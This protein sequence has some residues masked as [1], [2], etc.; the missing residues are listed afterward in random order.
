[1]AFVQGMR[2]SWVRL[3]IVVLTLV[4]VVFVSL[5]GWQWFEDARVEV[6]DRSLFAGYV[7]VTA[8]PT[9]EFENPVTTSGGNVVLSF[10]V[11][12]LEKSCVPSWGGA[13]TLAEANEQ[14]DLDRRIA[15]VRQLNGTPVVSFGGQANTELAAACASVDRIAGAYEQVVERYDL[16]VID[17]D[18]EGEALADTAAHQRRAEA[19]VQLQA[20]HD[21]EVWVTLPVA[22]HGLTE[23]GLILVRTMLDAGVDLAGVNVM[24]M[25]YGAGK[26]PEASMAEASIEALK[27]THEQLSTL[28]ESAG[29]RQTDA[30][31]WRLIGATPMLGQNDVREE[32]FDLDDASEF[33]AFADEIELGRMSV[34]SLNRDRSC[35]ANWPDVSKVSDSCSGVAQESGAF[36]SVLG[37]GGD[38][39]DKA[40]APS[41]EAS[42]SPSGTPTPRGGQIIDDPATSPYPVW[43]PANA[44]RTGDRVV[45]HQNV[46]VTKWWT[47]GDVP[48]DP[49]VSEDVSPWRLVGPVLAGEPP[50]PEPTLPAGTLP[51]WRPGAVYVAGTR[52]ELAGLGY[53]SQWWT[54]GTSPDAPSTQDAP[55]PWRRLTVPE[56]AALEK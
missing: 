21:T 50:E 6:A 15:R 41:R 3:G 39:P 54:R 42:P 22:P 56:L 28:Y 33:K 17:L 2:L 26:D 16:D 4:A 46:Y 27:S 45:W 29:Q 40:L 12:D 8:T 51:A 52:V 47:S 23:D 49:T 35:S 44:Y 34:W 24:T 32:V 25:D 30:Q 9:Y 38:G 20:E 10:V 37:G 36:A 31:V 48:D 18:I 43:S 14:L 5:R 7:D 53:V 13:Y 1:M 19:I 11:A 55:N